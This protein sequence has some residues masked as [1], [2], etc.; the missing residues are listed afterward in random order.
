MVASSA[1]KAAAV[2]PDI[3]TAVMSA[4]ISRHTEMPTRSATYR[5]APNFCSCTAPTK[6]M[7]APTNPLT[8][9]TMGRACTLACDARRAH[10]AIEGKGR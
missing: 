9:H 6:A 5:P 7:M 8:T 4:A 3:T 10:C 1:A 2:R